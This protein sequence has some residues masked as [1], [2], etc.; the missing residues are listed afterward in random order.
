LYPKDDSTDVD[1]TSSH[2]SPRPVGGPASLQ[3]ELRREPN[4]VKRFLKILGPGLVTGASDDDP[5]GIGTYAAAGA[6]L[7]YSCL[8]MAL[9][10]FPLMACVQFICAKIG[11]VSGRGIAGVLREH[12]PRPLLYVVVLGLLAANTINAGADILAIAAGINLLV[13]VPISVVM[14]PIAVAIIVLQVWGSY[15]LIARTFK[16]L[17]LALF[18]YIGSAFFARPDWGDVLR[19]T[20]LPTI[21]FDRTFLAMLVAVLGTTISPYLFFW[22]ASQE[23]EE[24]IAR[25]RKHLWQRK[26]ATDD[27][28]KYAFWDVS[29][30]MLFSN[31]V[32][33][34]ILLASAATLHQAGK[35]NIE[36]AAEAAEA[37]R[38]LAGNAATIF[39]ALGLIGTG[40]LAVPILTGSAAYAVCEMAGWKCGL[41]RRPGKAKE[42]YLVLGMS[43]L[44]GLL[45]DLVGVSPINA[46]LW[47][48]IIN[49]FLA[50]PLLVVIMLVA[51]HEG[52][53]GKRVNTRWANVLGWTTTAVMFAAALGFV[54]TWQDTP[55]PASGVMTA[56]PGQGTAGNVA[57]AGVMH[58]DRLAATR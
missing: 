29:I 22:Q 50:P 32:M 49:G 16:W 13:G 41:D 2:V 1:T 52:I 33:Y 15:R 25:G 40:L 4:P 21:H 14:V 35:T 38:P 43:T 3:D 27:E 56:V 54:A 26:G 55:G 58:P 31:V 7:G 12:Y 36:T 5:S 23:V 24:E 11:L 19:G 45:I 20:L 8:W 53:M 51:N 48:A 44:G 10:T 57:P 9:V 47:T 42:F 6:Q 37:L 39:M 18:A 28:L 34:F 17:T 30:G 46:L